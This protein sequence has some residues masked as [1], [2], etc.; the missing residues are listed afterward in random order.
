MKRIK[1]F[2]ASSIEDLKDDRI[3]VGDF[4]RQLNELYLDS[5]IHFSLIKC[6]DYDQSI[7]QFGKQQQYDQEIRESELVF[8]L[9]FRKVGEYTRHELEV[10]LE[11]FQNHKKP[12][13]I[14]YF[15]YVNTLDETVQEV[16]DFM[17]LLDQQL[18]H[19]YNTYGHIDTL[20][21]GILMQIKLLQ[22]DD[23]QVKLEDGVVQ[24][25]GQPMVNGKNVPLLQGNRS[26]QELMQKR[27]QLQEALACCRSDYLADPTPEKEAAFFDA[28]AELNRVSKQLTV[29]EQ[30]TMA[31]LTTV[32]EMTTDGRVL[33][34]RQKE[35]LHYFNLGDYEAVHTILENEERENELQRAKLRAEAAK[36]E[37][38]GYVEEELLLIKTERAQ[39]L[40]ALRVER[41]LS[42]YQK[43]EDLVETYGLNRSVLIDYVIFLHDQNRFDEAVLVAE[44]LKRYYDDPSTTAKDEDVAKLY[45]VLGSS[46]QNKRRLHE[47]KEAYDK[48]L[49]I[50]TRL[51]A[52]NPEVYELP[53]V[54]SRI[55]LGNLYSSVRR[56]TEAEIY[57]EA[58]VQMLARLANCKPES[59][60][61]FLAN[62]YNNQGCLFMEVGRHQE[63]KDAFDKAIGIITRLVSRDPQTYE[64]DL[65]KFYNN[66]GA[67]YTDMKRYSEAEEAIDKALK[68]RNRLA[69]CN[70]EAHT[71]HLAT[72]YM[73]LGNVYGATGRYKEAKDTYST[74]IRIYTKLTEHYPAI[75]ELELSKCYV[76]LGD[77]Y[78]HNQELKEAEAAYDKELALIMGLAQQRP[79]DYGMEL[80]NSYTRR[81]LHYAKHKQER[82]LLNMAN[83]VQPLFDKIVNKDPLRY[84]SQSL[85]IAEALKRM[86]S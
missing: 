69:D 39:G 56:Y 67:L 36:M 6:E 73:N 54:S 40:T 55:N 79:D 43:V 50:R 33:T 42:S 61:P 24:L 3:Q 34:R 84:L 18:K 57:Y 9:F 74:S 17:N 29:V 64:S 63:A 83:V 16:R 68:I 4:F 60:E 14:T 86:I 8:F 26:L 81:I 51:A 31:L 70:P 41:I 78:W 45:N 5:N 27:R 1:I 25:N 80:V 7:S 62:G 15:K 37:I 12:R 71:P 47:A 11:A 44:K 72:Y 22:L 77:V 85:Q 23:A 66:L 52:Q 28:S 19:Y 21:L 58:G 35:A 32:V 59:Y 20:K 76:N 13:I 82:A 10:A 65:A 75:Y 48:A 46:Y 53:L 30:E 38:Q 2:L 49:E